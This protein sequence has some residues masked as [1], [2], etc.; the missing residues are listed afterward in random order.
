MLATQPDYDFLLVDGWHYAVGATCI[1]VGSRPNPALCP[2]QHFT[3]TY[4]VL[5]LLL[6]PLCQLPPLAG[7]SQTGRAE[8]VAW[9]GRC[10][11]RI[12]PGC[13]LDHQADDSGHAGD[14]GQGGWAMTPDTKDHH[15]PHH[16]PHTPW[17]GSR[18]HTIPH[19][20][21][22]PRVKNPIRAVTKTC[23]A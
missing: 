7:P 1:F 15:C 3:F 5:P 20:C 21:C 18:P 8:A 10:P 2:A 6:L 9:A 16:C 13:T 12:G 4:P 19:R 11:G 22:T 14:M 17:P 23:Q